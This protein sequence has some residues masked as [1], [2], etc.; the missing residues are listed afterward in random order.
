[1]VCSLSM[2]VF[3]CICACLYTCVSKFLSHSIVL[4]VPVPMV[5]F[6][7]QNVATTSA[8]PQ[9]KHKKPRNKK[10]MS[11]YIVYVQWLHECL[12][13]SLC[14]AFHVQCQIFVLH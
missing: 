4:Q 1:M 6:P 14:L 2:Y 12:S 13:I 7:Q 8:P 10:R 5:A 9:A 11:K 3:M